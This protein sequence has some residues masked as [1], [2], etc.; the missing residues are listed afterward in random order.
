MHVNMDSVM[1]NM[2]N[3]ITCFESAPRKAL[4]MVLSHFLGKLRLGNWKRY[5][6]KVMLAAT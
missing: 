6:K 1:L 2:N 5:K 4:K 3:K